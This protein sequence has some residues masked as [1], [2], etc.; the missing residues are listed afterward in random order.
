M[1]GRFVSAVGGPTVV[2]QRAVIV[3][4][5]EVP[6]LGETPAMSHVVVGQV[7]GSGDPGPGGLP[8]DSPAGFV[9]DYHGG[10][11]DPPAGLAGYP[12]QI[13]RGGLSRLAQRP[14]GHVQSESLREEPGD[15]GERHSQ[16]VMQPR[17]PRLGARSDLGTRRPQ[18]VR[19]LLTMSALDSLAARPAT[20]YSHLET[21]SRRRW[22]RR[23]G[24][25]E[26]IGVTLMF[27]LPA[28]MRT[29]L[30]QRRL[31]RAIRISRSHTM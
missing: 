10:V 4:V 25:L 6:G 22:Q 14:G 28:A 31:Q 26:L 18:S 17:R 19:G 5:D 29:G 30:M 12:D 1:G 8:A 9:H 2:H 11:V 21:G 15:L 13:G 27:D 16:A 20:S 24:G 3:G 23:Q 7:D